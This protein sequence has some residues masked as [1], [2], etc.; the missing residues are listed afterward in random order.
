LELTA[1][2][3]YVRGLAPRVKA[4]EAFAADWG[5]AEAERDRVL[6]E[7][8]RVETA[9]GEARQELLRVEAERDRALA[10]WRRAEGALGEAVRAR[11]LLEAAHGALAGELTRLRATVT[12]RLR[13]AVLSR[14]A[15]RRVAGLAARCASRWLAEG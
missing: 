6:A 11:A 7:C 8:R 14:P 1:A 12:F 15:L 3:R 9:L 13:E 5:A 2:A 4:V 10:E